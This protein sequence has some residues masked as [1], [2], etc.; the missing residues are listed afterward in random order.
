VRHSLVATTI[1]P[2]TYSASVTATVAAAAGGSGNAAS[3]TVHGA[4]PTAVA[5]AAATASPQLDFLSLRGVLFDV[6]GTLVE[7]DPLHFLA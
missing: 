7:S 3:M 6:D 2:R 5:T 4:A 1:F